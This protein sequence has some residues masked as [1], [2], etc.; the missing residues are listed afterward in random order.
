MMIVLYCECARMRLWYT[1][2]DTRCA[3][4]G[5][6]QPALQQAQPSQEPIT[7]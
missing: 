1:S 2:H 7:L 5:R 3:G 6:W 4:I